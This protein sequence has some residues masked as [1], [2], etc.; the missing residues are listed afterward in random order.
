VQFCH[1]IPE[2]D[3]DGAHGFGA[4]VIRMAGEDAR[5]TAGD[6]GAVEA[7]VIIG[8]PAVE[9]EAAAGAAGVKRQQGQ[10]PAE[11]K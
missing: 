4:G 5:P 7:A 9:A 8:R 11:I 3:E 1:L 2:A 10:L 6:L